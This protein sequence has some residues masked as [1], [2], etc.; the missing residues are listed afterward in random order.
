MGE[1]TTL[2]REIVDIVQFLRK[3]GVQHF[4]VTDGVIDVKFHPPGQ[5]MAYSYDESDSTHSDE[6]SNYTLD[7]DTN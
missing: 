6:T 5:A 3:N 4:R 7:K 1:H 2:D